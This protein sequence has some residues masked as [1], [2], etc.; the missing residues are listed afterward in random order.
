MK[1]IKKTIILA[2]CAATAISAFGCS[3]APAKESAAE[4]TKTEGTATEVTDATTAETAPRAAE[5]FSLDNK[6]PEEIFAILKDLA[7]IKDGMTIAEFESK[8]PVGW[9]E[10]GDGGVYYSFKHDEQKDLNYIKSVTPPYPVDGVFHKKEG[11]RLEG[12]LVV[13][14][15]D[16]AQAIFDLNKEYLTSVYGESTGPVSALAGTQ[17]SA[18]FKT[19][20]ITAGIHYYCYDPDLDTFEIRYLLPCPDLR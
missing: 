8:F 1:S 5:L 9:S 20:T 16:K 7:D 4:S 11:S 13:Q 10:K 15:K 12:Y 3:S 19:E 17:D 18:A 2:L 14:G 6:T